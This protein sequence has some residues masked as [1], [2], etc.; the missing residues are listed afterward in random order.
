MIAFN[1]AAQ[2]ASISVVCSPGLSATGCGD[3]A[4]RQTTKLLLAPGGKVLASTIQENAPMMKEL[5]DVNPTVFFPSIPHL[6]RSNPSVLS[7][8]G[9]PHLA[10][11]AGC[12]RGR[13]WTA[14]AESGPL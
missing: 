7:V 6:V 9:S 13:S 11:S 1:S 2:S 5:L 8:S 12:D 3:V 14:H 10:G 4:W